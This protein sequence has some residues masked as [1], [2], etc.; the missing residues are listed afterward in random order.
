MLRLCVYVSVCIGSIDSEPIVIIL[1]TDF[2]GVNNASQALGKI[3]LCAALIDR[4]F[5]RT[6]RWPTSCN[7]QHIL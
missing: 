3:R 5:G 4:C 2:C 7:Q 1:F 6:A